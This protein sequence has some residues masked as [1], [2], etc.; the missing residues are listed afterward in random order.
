MKEER[1]IE[2]W[3]IVSVWPGP[4]K[5][6]SWC[7]TRPGRRTEWIGSWTLPPASLDQLGSPRRGARRRVDLPVVV[8][9]DDL[10]LGHVL[11]DELRRLHHQ[12]RPDG[13]V[14]RH[15]QVRAS[16]SFE[17]GEVRAGGPHHAMDPCLDAMS[18]VFQGR[19]R[20]REVHDHVG[21]TENV[22]QR[23]LEQ[24]IRAPHQR[25]VVGALDGVADRLSHSPRRAGDGDVDHAAASAGETASSARRKVVSS[26]PTPAAAIRSGR[27]NS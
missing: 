18:C 7:A 16:H 23:V 13:E 14:R 12:H 2:S 15:E 26:P 17:R 20:S 19:V 4:P 9:L 10:A 6:T 1:S 25:H 24:R 22:E 27:Q 3:R 5:M 8:Q 21:V 11:G